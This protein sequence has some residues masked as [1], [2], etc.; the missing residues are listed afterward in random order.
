MD[1]FVRSRRL[2]GQ[3]AFDRLS[4]AHVLVVGVGGVG[5]HLVEALVRTGLGRLTLVD[6]D[7][8]SETDLNRQVQALISTLGTYKVKALGDRIQDINPACQLTLHPQAYQCQHLT[9]DLDYVVDCVDDVE[10]KLSIITDARERGLRVISS[11]GTGNKLDPSQLV[12]TDISKTHTC[13]LARIMRKRL[14]LLG[15]KKLDV[16]TST[17]PPKR[18]TDGERGVASLATVPPAAGLF[19]ASHVIRVVGRLDEETAQ[20]RE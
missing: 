3:A 17:E 7:R 9:D 10:A 4:R 18:F 2:L 1:A 11:M 8:V 12:I 6:Y 14:R 5:S 20:G 15:I 16:L 13:P 19:L